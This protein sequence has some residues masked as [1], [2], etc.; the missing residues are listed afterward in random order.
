VLVI[1]DLFIINYLCQLSALWKI[2]R[3]S[4][5]INLSIN[6]KLSSNFYLYSVDLQFKKSS[7]IFRMLIKTIILSLLLEFKTVE[8][9]HC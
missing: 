6:T 2:M 3:E 5:L 1:Y 4:N 8:K 9:V 7:S